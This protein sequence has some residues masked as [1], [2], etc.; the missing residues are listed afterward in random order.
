MKP[1][2]KR[3]IY[4]ALGV[5]SILVLT[6]PTVDDAAEHYGVFSVA[7]KKKY[8]FLLFSVYECPDIDRG[9][10]VES[11]GILKNFIEFGEAD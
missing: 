10:R 3:A 8:N 5:I 1:A 7:V 11:V 9:V 2:Y 6:N 4:V